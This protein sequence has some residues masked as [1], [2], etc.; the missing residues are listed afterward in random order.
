MLMTFEKWVSQN[1][2]KSIDYDGVY[3]VQ[4][5]DLV[6]HYIKNVLGVKPESIG[7]A[8]EYYNKRKT[9]E[10]LTKNFKWIDN[11][12]EFVPKKGDLCVFTSRSGNG[13]ISVATG[14]GT[15][16][17]FYS[18]DQNFPRAKHEPM[19]LVKHSYT[20][21]LGVLRPKKKKSAVKCFKS[22]K[23][24]SLSIVDALEAIGAKSDFDYRKKIAVKNKIKD[25]K[26]APEQNE[27]MLALLKKGKLIK[28]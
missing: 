4:C 20:S 24:D 27:K 28:P 6:K 12:A 19:T 21:F 25:Y 7:N 17:Y 26:G 3:G 14:E 8:I 9:S 15:T 1:L 2:G 18:Y 13:H 16:S 22:Y 23:G 10:Y 5:V 11:T